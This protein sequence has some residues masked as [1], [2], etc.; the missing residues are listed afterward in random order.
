MMALGPAER[1]IERMKLRF[2]G[3]TERKTPELAQHLSFALQAFFDLNSERVGSMSGPGRIPWRAIKDYG[4]F[5]S[6]DDSE[7]E[8][9]VLYISAMDN[10]FIDKLM[11]K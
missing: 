9:L 4:V 8:Q 5:Y 1:D 3:P 2:G 6:M 7:L 10:A 11:E